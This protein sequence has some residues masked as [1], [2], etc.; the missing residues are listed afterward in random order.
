MKLRH[1]LSILV[2]AGLV[3]WS[4][5]SC[6]LFGTT[7][8]KRVSDFQ[9]DLNT[10]SRSNVYNNFH[11]TQT[12][13]YNALKDPVT[14]GFNTTYPPPGPSYSL[15]IVDKSNTSAVIVLVSAGLHASWVAPYFLSLNMA[16]Y[17]GNDWR[18][19]SISDSQ[20]NGSYTV[21]Y[22]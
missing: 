12:S 19:V 18:I 22:Q 20:T 13:Q 10:A 9:G 2:G 21:R 14:V 3:L 11:P 8:D 7:I 17:N 1:I 4:L 16:Q 15:S 6:D 5:A